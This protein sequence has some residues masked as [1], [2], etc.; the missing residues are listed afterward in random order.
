MFS[1]RTSRYGNTLLKLL[2]VKISG[3]FAVLTCQLASL[4]S[5]P[6]FVHFLF[7]TVL[8]N[9]SLPPPS[10]LEDIPLSLST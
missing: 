4:Y 5:F 1:P 6:D 7:L 8:A 9:P 10:T 3:H 2:V